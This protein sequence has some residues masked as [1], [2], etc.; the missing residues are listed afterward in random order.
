[1]ALGKGPSPPSI[2]PQFRAFLTHHHV[3]LIIVAP[4][5]TARSQRLVARLGLRST[6][7]DDVLIYRVR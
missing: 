5:A 3:A 7:T 1:M 4:G 6:R 2:E